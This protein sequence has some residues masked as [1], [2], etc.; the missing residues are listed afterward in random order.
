M[1]WGKRQGREAHTLAWNRGKVGGGGSGF[2][3]SV[4]GPAIFLFLFCY[5]P[6][7]IYH[8]LDKYFK[9]LEIIFL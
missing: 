8:N 6:D 1:K 3:L 7:K 5:W 9:L 4:K 2:D